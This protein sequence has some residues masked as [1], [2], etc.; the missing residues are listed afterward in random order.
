MKEVKYGEVCIGT[1]FK[2]RKFPELRQVAQGI[3]GGLVICSKELKQITE[4][5][6]FCPVRRLVGLN[7]T[8]RFPFTAQRLENCR[9]DHWSFVRP[10][11]PGDISPDELVEKLNSVIQ[12][13][14]PNRIDIKLNLVRSGLKVE[15]ER[16]SFVPPAEVEKNK[17][18]LEPEDGVTYYITKETAEE[19]FEKFFQ[20]F[21]LATVQR[22]FDMKVVKIDD[23]YEFV[24][25]GDNPEYTCSS[26]GS[27]EKK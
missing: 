14:G 9:V 17:K 26:V 20:K 2:L 25:R 8:S 4:F 3:R 7:Y 21:I 18:Y 27:E 24:L 6:D 15:W 5:P 11:E 12:K 16:E 19:R 22:Y 1:D 23:G 10:V 13:Y